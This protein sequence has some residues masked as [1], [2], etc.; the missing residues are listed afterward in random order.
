MLLEILKECSWKKNCNCNLQF[1]VLLL[2]ETVF[3]KL[4]QLVT[5]KRPYQ[6]QN[7]T[8]LSCKKELWTTSKSKLPFFPT[9]AE[10]EK[11]PICHA[12]EHVPVTRWIAYKLVLTKILIRARSIVYFLLK[13][14]C[15]IAW[16]PYISG[17][18]LRVLEAQRTCH[19]IPIKMLSLMLNLA[20]VL[21]RIW[22]LV[23]NPYTPIDGFPMS[24]WT[25]EMSMAPI[26]FKLLTFNWKE[27]KH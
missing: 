15:K 17:E 23:K 20:A 2:M 4:W 1:S 12:Q 5:V 9:I 21:L 24:T 16:S 7:Q 27:N 11:N 6:L 19:L 26:R 22:S 25:K 18:L 3:Y 10:I 8:E 13:T 14:V